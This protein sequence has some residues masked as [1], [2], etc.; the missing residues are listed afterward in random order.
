MIIL[1]TI[2]SIIGLIVAVWYFT[3]VLN[4]YG[5]SNYPMP[6]W[7]STGHLI[8]WVLI[9]IGLI[10]L[11]MLYRSTQDS[12][13]FLKIIGGI[14]LVLLI[15]KN[16]LTP[17]RM[18]FNDVMGNLYSGGGLRF[19]G[20]QTSDF[21]GATEPL[22]EKKPGVKDAIVAEAHYLVSWLHNFPEIAFF[23]GIVLCKSLWVALFLFV[24]AFILEIIRFYIF[25][26]S[27]LLSHTCRI[28]NW[29]RIPSFSIAAI[30][31]WPE[32][33]FLSITL[34]LFLIIQGWFGL[35]SSVGMLPIRLI[36][37]RIIYRKYG[38]DWHNMEG[39]TMDFVIN[40]WRLKLFPA[41]RFN[42]DK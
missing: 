24:L 9:I 13:L 11:I 33:S 35:V 8:S 3:S 38:G 34:I 23:W 1:W 10:S 42:L 2:L 4:P 15:V 40:R 20:F 31:F 30:I 6:L 22:E 7:K 12:T 26:A 29:V 19:G 21:L 37:G 36:A 5:R 18:P 32:E 41:D 14:F 27:P 17:M 25:G 39:M 28:W 16:K